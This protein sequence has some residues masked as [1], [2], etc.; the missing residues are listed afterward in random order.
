MSH[1]ISAG[2]PH[3]FAQRVGTPSGRGQAIRGGV[4]R[5]DGP[6]PSW[7]AL[8]PLGVDVAWKIIEDKVGKL[9]VRS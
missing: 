9:E 8:G 5:W 4:G 1:G 2:P 6:F 3:Q 7:S